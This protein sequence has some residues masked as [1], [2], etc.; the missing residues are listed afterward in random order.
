MIHDFQSCE[1]SSILPGA[2]L[3]SIQRSSVAQWWSRR[4][5]IARLQVRV[6]PLEYWG[7]DETGIIVVLHATFASSNLAGSIKENVKYA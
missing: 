2:M 6:L 4:L 5:L 3:S 1:G 7:Y